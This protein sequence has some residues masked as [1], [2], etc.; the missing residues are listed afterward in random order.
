[1]AK[2]SKPLIATD[3]TCRGHGF[4]SPDA[5]YFNRACSIAFLSVF[6]SLCESVHSKILS[7][8]APSL[9]FP[10]TLDYFDEVRTRSK[11]VNNQNLTMLPEKCPHPCKTRRSMGGEWERDKG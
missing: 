3:H 6:I 1:M 2:R 7:L 4:S 11:M 9:P 8:L 5:S 10:P